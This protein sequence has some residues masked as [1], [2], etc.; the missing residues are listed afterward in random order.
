MLRWLACWATCTQRDSSKADE[1]LL[2]DWSERKKEGKG[3]KEMLNIWSDLMAIYYLPPVLGSW[4]SERTS[5]EWMNGPGI[6]YSP[7]C[8]SSPVSR[9]TAARGLF[10]ISNLLT[11]DCL[12][13]VSGV[14]RFVIRLPCLDVVRTGEHMWLAA[15]ILL[16]SRL[17][18]WPARCDKITERNGLCLS[19]GA[20]YSKEFLC[21]VLLQ[22]SYELYGQMGWD[23][24]RF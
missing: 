19:S 3:K 4:L 21:S 10:S 8:K 17:K 23:G 18:K 14:A 24:I 20:F 6:L 22:I 12:C 15:G 1:T 5:E 2:L 13:L 9:V 7:L 16:I 11:I